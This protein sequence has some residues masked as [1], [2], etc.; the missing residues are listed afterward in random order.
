[1]TSIKVSELPSITTPYNGSEFTLGIQNGISVKVP[2]LNLTASTGSTLVGTIQSGTGAVSRTVQSKLRESISVKDFGAVGDGVADDTAAIQAALNQGQTNN[3]T[4]FVPAGIYKITSTLNITDGIFFTGENMA[5]TTINI[6]S[7]TNIPAIKVYTSPSIGK[8]IFG[9]GVSNLHITCNGNCD[10]ILISALYPYPITRAIYENIRINNTVIGFKGIGDTANIVYMNIFRNIIVEGSSAYGFYANGCCYNL[11][12]HI[13]SSGV[14]NTSF[15]FAILDAGATLNNF[16][17]EGVGFIDIPY[18][19]CSNYTVETIS[20]ATP[21]TPV[22]VKF[23]RASNVSNVTL[24]DVD[25]SKCQ[26]G[27]ALGNDSIDLNGV[28]FINLTTTPPY[29]PLT[30]DPGGSGVISNFMPSGGYKIEQYQPTVAKD[31]KFVN[32]PLLTNIYNLNSH[33]V[34]SLPTATE[35][36]RAD[37]FS[38]NGVGGDQDKSYL[39]TN[40][41]TGAYQWSSLV[42][43]LSGS[44][45]VPTATATSFFTLPTVSPGFWIISISLNSNAVDTWSS[46]YLVSTQN[47]TSNITPLHAGTGTGFSLSISALTLKMNQSSGNTF[48]MNWSITRLS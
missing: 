7:A 24:I 11:W 13:E 30:C 27:I 46:T 23:N 41:G 6:V 26:Y 20:A 33:I 14:S 12:E 47:A 18:G 1:M 43:T 9:G 48:D 40:D 2:A 42:S 4:V 5:S 45:S 38:V 17:S 3:S 28:K 15:A 25:N 35:S 36:F 44:I 39:C 32:C 21:A 34:T 22:A 19:S 31:Y 8:T 10:G 37:I 16:T 29:Y